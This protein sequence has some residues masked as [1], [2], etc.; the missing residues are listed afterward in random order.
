MRPQSGDGRIRRLGVVALAAVLGLASAGAD[1]AT[2]SVTTTADSGAG[3]LRQAIT[4]ANAGPGPD[5]IAF[6]IGAVGSQQ[7][8]QPT[9]ALPSITDPVII[10]GW[11]Q[12]GPGFTGPPLIELSGALTGGSAYALRITA[13]G[14]TVRG[15]T[16]NGYPSGTGV[17]LMTVGGN[18]IYGNFIGVDAAGSTAVPNS[19]GIQIAFASND[20]IIGTDGDGV[21]DDVEGNLISGN[22]DWGIEFAQA[23]TL[24]NVVAGNR[25][26]TDVSGLLAIPNGTASLSRGGI[27]L[28]SVANRIGTNEDSVSDELERNLISGNNGTGILVNLQIDSAAVPNLIAGNYIGAD[29]GGLAA[30]P[31]TGSGLSSVVSPTFNYVIRGNVISGNGGGGITIGGLYQAVITG[32]LIGVGSDGTTPMGNTGGP[33]ISMGGSDNQIGGA[34][35]GD[36]NTIANNSADGVALVSWVRRT[37]IRGNRIY[38]NSG[39]GIDLDHNGVTLNDAGDGDTGANELQNFPVLTGAIRI[40][41]F[42]IGSLTCVLVYLLTARAAPDS[43]AAPLAAGMAAA[44]YGTLAFFD[45]DLLMAPL[46]LFFTCGALLL[47]SLLGNPGGE[48][49]EV[50]RKGWRAALIALAAGV[51]LGLAGLGK[52]NILLFAPFALV[53]IVTGFALRFKWRRWPEAILFAVGC[54]A[55]VAPITYRNHV[56]SDDFVLVSSNAGVNLYIGNNAEAEGI[57]M[58]PPGSGLDNTRLYLSSRE[59]AERET[60]RTGLRPSEV[61]AWWTSRATDY[62]RSEPGDALSLWW[63]KFR[64]FWNHYEIPNHHNKQFVTTYYAAFLDVLIVGFKLVAPL[65]VLGIVLMFL[66]GPASSVNRLFAGF[67]FVYMLSLIPFFITARYRLPVVPFLVVFASYGVFTMARVLQKKKWRRAGI[68]AGAGLAAAIFV[69]WPMVDY[70]FAFSHTVVGSVYSELATEEPENAAEHME[71]AIVEY[72]TALELRP[73]SVDAH[74]NLGVSYQRIGFHSGAVEE[75]ETAVRLQPGHPW[76]S[77]ALEEARESLS[78]EGDRIDALAVPRTNFERGVEYSRRRQY[79]QAALLYAQVLRKDVHHPGAWSQLGAID[80]DAGNYPQAIQKFKKGLK[81][82]PAHF[83]L[84]NNIA[85]AYYKL[86]DTGK[87]RRH[88]QLCLEVDPGNEAVLR[89]LELLDDD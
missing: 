79:D 48:D 25:I 49:P 19:R 41:Q 43:K 73:L 44:L 45:G 51:L 42:I 67:I 31:N 71:T 72:K 78:R 88:W 10:D 29:A 46:V 4:D 40:I 56:V 89:Q 14:T 55:A 84:N 22:K 36:G 3:S 2:Y 8:I 87:A 24:N 74:Y 68:A 5:T 53:W 54:V 30:L 66:T 21:A 47:L 59:V 64:L 26:G 17:I 27:W 12:G 35:P 33:G 1:A 62:L 58:L 57:F 13:G 82:N 77:K 20:N 50:P 76:A 80:F 39:L 75:L 23:G 16:I 65:A 11:S 86:G 63:H 34:A 15:L 81:Y 32:N 18:S 7:T 37:S 6:A 69:S 70:D 28:G 83:V 85:G 38:A 52:P 61:S 9:S 60:G